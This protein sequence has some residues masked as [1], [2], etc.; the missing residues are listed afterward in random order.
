MQHLRV[1]ACSVLV[2]AG[3]FAS[4]LVIG[5]DCEGR[6]PTGC[7]SNAQCL[8]GQR[9][10]GGACVDIP[11]AAPEPP[12]TPFVTFDSPFVCPPERECGTECCNVGQRCYGGSMCLRDLGDCT[13]NDDCWDDSYCDGGACTPYG[14]PPTVTS[15]ATCLRAGTLSGIEP[16]V[17]CEWTGPPAGDRYPMHNQ[18]M[19][20]PAIVDFDMDDDDGTLEPSIVFVSFPTSRSVFADGVLRVIDGGDCHQIASLDDAPLVAASSPAVGDLDGDGRAEIVALRRPN[21]LIAW[22]WDAGTDA[23]VQLWQSAICNADGTRSEDPIEHENRWTSVSIHDLDDDGVPEILD[24][25]AVYDVNGCL[26]FAGIAGRD[27]Y[28][29]GGIA[30]VADVDEDG[31]MELVGGDTIWSWN[32]TMHTLEPES[33]VTMSQPRGLVAVADFGNYPIDA[34]GG[35]DVAEIAVV[36]AGTLRVQT[37]DGTVVF[38]PHPIPFDAMYSDGGNGGAPTIADFDGDGRREVATAGGSRYVVFDLDCV[39]GGDAANCG[40]RAETNG[41]LWAQG[42]QDQTSNVTGS[43]VFDFDHDGAAEVVYADECF[44]RI[45]EGA[46]GDIVYSA[47]RSSATAYENPVIADVDGDFHTEIVASANDYVLMGL[48]C[49]SADPLRPT[50]EYH[51][52]HGIVVY[53]DAMDRW[54]ASRRIWSQHAYAITHVGDLGEIPRSSAV[55]VNWRDPELN[56]FRQNVQGDLEALGVADLTTREISDRLRVPCGSDGT[57][58]LSARVCNRGALPMGAGFVVSFRSGMRDGPELCRASSPVFLGVAECDEV[59]CTAHLPLGERIDVYVVADPDGEQHECHEGNNVGLQPN[60]AC[61][62]V[63]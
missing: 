43:S 34:L 47:A 8:A 59:S 5:C 44:L 13:T 25:D 32:A 39:D 63:D 18:A 38:G 61:D 6:V 50:S 22:R 21:G 41:I 16:D 4:F 7:T 53:R 36:S 29:R 42:S 58:T 62:T 28:M 57:A 17:Q 33:Y 40:G 37:V 46:T 12:D 30:V 24:D 31:Q 56:N 9:C 54:A 23:F 11:D 49:P 20:T 51:A 35:R 60:V 19:S 2:V 15:D 3:A 27:P 45:Y 1:S 26:M 10:L 14:V 48:G 52:T 55:A